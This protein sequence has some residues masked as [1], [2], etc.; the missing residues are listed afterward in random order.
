VLGENNQPVPIEVLP[1]A[2]SYV[3]R[4]VGDAGGKPVL[5]E[6]VRKVGP[7][8]T[9]NGNFIIDVGFGPIGRPDVLERELKTISGIVETGLFVKMVNS[10]YL[11]KRRGVDKLDR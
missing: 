3:M 9:D 4:K 1:F 11:G 7:V 8:I 10:V 5:R 6:G 2:A